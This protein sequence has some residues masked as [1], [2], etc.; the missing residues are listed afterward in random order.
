MVVDWLERSSCNAESMGS[1]LASY[2]Y[3]SVGTYSMFFAHNNCS[4][5][6]L[7][8]RRRGVYTSALPNL[9]LRRVISKLNCIVLL[10][11]CMLCSIG[12]HSIRLYLYSIFHREN[13][14]CLRELRGL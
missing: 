12:F 4:A 8:L 6:L 14:F 9:N 13:C 2:S 5:I 1:S 11:S 10:Y 3:R 7:H